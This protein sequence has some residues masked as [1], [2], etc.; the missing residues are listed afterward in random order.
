MSIEPTFWKVRSIFSKYVKQLSRPP[1][2]S[3]FGM[4][5][6]SRPKLNTLLTNVCSLIFLQNTEELQRENDYLRQQ[7]VTLA[8]EPEVKV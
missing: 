7:V 6:V 1:F 4:V 8:A 3:K 5:Y 2:M